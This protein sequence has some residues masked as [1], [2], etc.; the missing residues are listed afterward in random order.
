MCSERR[1]RRQDRLPTSFR[2]LVKRKLNEGF[3]AGP[4]TAI[5]KSQ[6]TPVSFDDLAA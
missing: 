3:A 1:D 2:G 4:V 6:G 5:P